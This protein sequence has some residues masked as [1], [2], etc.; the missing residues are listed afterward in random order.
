MKLQKK[1]QK[2]LE[3]LREEKQQA[4]SSGDP[5]DQDQQV[6]REI[7]KAMARR[8][9]FTLEQQ[10]KD[11]NPFATTDINFGSGSGTVTS[12]PNPALIAGVAGIIACI[13][14]KGSGKKIN[15][16]LAK[17]GKELIK[18]LSK[19]GLKTAV[20]GGAMVRF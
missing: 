5:N 12:K 11:P 17:G 3:E 9:G 1:I 14:F 20:K 4:G 15:P 16:L 19:T 2:L 10:T 8:G 7:L 13:T 6:M 18:G